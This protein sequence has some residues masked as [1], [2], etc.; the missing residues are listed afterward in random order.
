M[1]AKRTACVAA[2]LALCLTQLLPL[3][4]HAQFRDGACKRG[5]G[6]TVI[7]DWNK[8]DG[9]GTAKRELIRCILL[10]EGAQDFPVLDDSGLATRSVLRSAGIAF[11][12]DSFITN[13][14]GIQ[15]PEGWNWFFWGGVDGQW[16]GDGFWN[17]EPKVDSFVGIA[18]GPRDQTNM[19]VRHPAFE[20]EPEPSPT[21]GPTGKPT[22]DPTPDPTGKPDPGPS[23]DPDP[24]PTGEP[25]PDPTPTP[26]PEPTP[27]VEPDSEP[28][29][30]PDPTDKPTPS[31]T[32]A[33]TSR[34]STSTPSH[35]EPPSVPPGT[36]NRPRPRPL[37]PSNT[38]T[39]N[40]S[41]T[42]HPTAPPN[43]P[44]P[45]ATGTPTPDASPTPSAQP[46]EDASGPVADAPS[47]TPSMVWGREE[48]Q[49]QRTPGQ[50]SST[51][52]SRSP[53]LAGALAVLIV[54]G[55]GT[56]AGFGIRA[57]HTPPLEDE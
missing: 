47:A 55:L 6:V 34:P 14:N 9:A 12:A 44:S 52:S 2:L 30:R 48:A 24:A 20:E 50:A 27:T 25:D 51:G 53:W 42:S 39:S 54:G 45:S 3:T 23:P 5:E 56:A 7:V 37:P 17:P 26:D 57:T 11:E 22:P 31:P 21:P 13:V 38:P 29:N 8:F 46:S 10:D 28:T 49:R 33:P 32:A 4:A 19:P 41:D 1:N 16:K 40:A 36:D 43:T 15:D 18:L 35:S